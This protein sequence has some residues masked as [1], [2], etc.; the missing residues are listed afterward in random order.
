MKKIFA[1]A[2]A[3]ML[4]I[5]L[6]AC[7]GKVVEEPVES[8]TQV[9]ETTFEVDERPISFFSVAYGI[10]EDEYSS[11]MIYDNQDGTAYVSYQAEV[12]KEGN[13]DISVLEGLNVVLA[14][15]KL[16]ALYGQEVYEDGYA[17]ASL[18]INYGDETMDSMMFTGEIPA[19]FIDG[20]S[21]L[22]AY[23]QLELKDMP[24]YVAKP[25][26]GEDL[27]EAA[28]AEVMEILNNADLGPLDMMAINNAQLD[29]P[30]FK[31]TV[32]IESAGLTNAIICGSMMMTTPYSFSIVTV[33]NEADIASVREAF[34]ADLQWTKWVCVFP[35][36]ALVAQKGNMVICLLGNADMYTETAAAIEA[37]GWQEIVT[38]RNPEAA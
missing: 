10:S 29:D 4:V 3:A 17:N 9:P 21:K 32:G 28:L 18:Q 19:E 25:V 15:T 31:D 14:S 27:D 26:M 38:E 36:D 37:A 34:L 22:Q 33:E 7:G 5:S 13:V 11:I 24:E 6:A 12:R 2:L 1:L 20:Y 35:T 8:T 16:P 23:F 30:F